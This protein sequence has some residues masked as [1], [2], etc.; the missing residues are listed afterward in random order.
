MND[1]TTH[2]ETDLSQ[3]PRVDQQ[4]TVENESWL[5]HLAVD[6]DPVYLLELRPFRGNDDRLSTLGSIY[7]GVS[8]G[9]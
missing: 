6:S 2:P 1:L 8:E 5:V 9:H 3:L 4:T 7:Y